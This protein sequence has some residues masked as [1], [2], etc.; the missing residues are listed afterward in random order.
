MNLI[1]KLY[2]KWMEEQH[3]VAQQEQ[4][5]AAKIQSLYRMYTQKIRY[6]SV[7][8]K[9]IVVQSVCRRFLAYLRIFRECGFSERYTLDGTFPAIIL[10]NGNINMTF[11]VYCFDG[12]IVN[13]VRQKNLLQLPFYA[14]L[15]T[16]H[17]LRIGDLVDASVNYGEHKYPGTIVYVHPGCYHYDVLF[18]GDVVPS[19]YIF[20]KNIHLS[21]CK[22]QNIG[23]SAPWQFHINENVETSDD[24][25]KSIAHA[26]VLKQKS[27]RNTKPI[28]DHKKTVYSLQI[29]GSKEIRH[30]VPSY[31]IRKRFR[32]YRP[33]LDIEAPCNYDKK[34]GST[35]YGIGQICS[36]ETGTNTCKVIFIGSS[37]SCKI[38]PF[39]QIRVLR[40][41]HYEIG[42]KILVANLVGADSQYPFF[43]R[44]LINQRKLSTRSATITDRGEH[45]Q[46]YKVS[47]ATGKQVSAWVHFSLLSDFQTEKR[48][49][50]E[51]VRVKV[52][53]H[54][55]TL[56][57]LLRMYA[58]GIR[59]NFEVWS[60]FQAHVRRRQQRKSYLQTRKK[61]VLL[62]A[63]ARRKCCEIKL[64][65]LNL[66]AEEIQKN[67]RCIQ[68][69]IQFQTI[70]TFTIK[71]QSI[72]RLFLCRCNYLNVRSKLTKLQAFARSI[73]CR[74]DLIKKWRVQEGLR[75]EISYKLNNEEYNIVLDDGTYL[76][77]VR[78]C[79][80]TKGYMCN[81]EWLASGTRVDATEDDWLTHF[82]AT[83]MGVTW[84]GMYS[85]IF[86]DTSSE[87]EV[88]VP[89]NAVRRLYDNAGRS[90]THKWH[91]RL[92]MTVDRWKSTFFVQVTKK[93]K[94]NCYNV[95]GLDNGK[96]NGKIYNNVKH[97]FLRQPF[98]ITN[99]SSSS[100][101]EYSTPSRKSKYSLGIIDTVDYEKK[102]CRVG[103]Q[104]YKS[105]N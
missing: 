14:A 67:I 2:A 10:R 64:R 56:K 3:R 90:L 22:N 97:S 79:C 5:H 76:S 50:Y 38:I 31:C 87:M 72:F 94:N 37:S 53:R 68:K 63:L 84:N 98:K 25:W 92:E 48:K 60:F 42:A 4:Y 21:H 81:E 52:A 20:I 44:K 47:F 77:N 74:R 71:L 95:Q 85:V 19:K 49:V 91:S 80:L 55:F 105:Q 29:I 16:P 61:V 51:I 59:R 89:R 8:T 96:F 32:K 62:Q 41:K 18:E 40:G 66:K 102:L 100:E 6:K 15:Y 101:V 103:R 73:V 86:D 93:L 43:I 70:R 28:K 104:S 69:V 57:M 39:S 54:N 23:S 34:D 9:Y 36:V 82:A 35:L 45:D 46:F 99:L 30:N 33:G 1:R 88:L 11:D 17:R 7:L 27:V 26:Y 24:K 75:G 58:S 12:S 78:K 65:F 83:I 13:N